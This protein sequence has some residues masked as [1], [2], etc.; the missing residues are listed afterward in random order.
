[1]NRAGWDV[2]AWNFRGCSG[3]PNRTTRAYH[4]GASDDLAAV[5]AHVAESAQPTQGIAVLGFSLGGNL[6]LKY[7]AELGNRPGP[8]CAA[9]AI[10]VPCDLASAAARMSQPASRLYL[11][12]FLRSMRAKA[13]AKVRRFPGQVP[14]RVRDTAWPSVRTFEAFDD[15]FT[16]PLHGFRD[17][18]DYYARCS[19]RPLLPQIRIPTLILNA[20]NDPFLSPEC[21]PR[22][23][24]KA[25]PQL[26]LEAPTGGGH[27]G[28]RGIGDRQNYW[29]ERRIVGFLGGY[30]G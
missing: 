26:W 7:A 2:V 16:A 5:V 1:L 6:T 15:C 25:N 30:K 17:A 20:A 13:M 29:H 3:E 21:F 14:N 18:A 12:N 19:A 8:I 27:V 10:S 11:D 28:F 23:E 4:S 9:V 24:A 22:A